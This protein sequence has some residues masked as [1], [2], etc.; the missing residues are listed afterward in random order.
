M[1]PKDYWFTNVIDNP[2]HTG[3]TLPTREWYSHIP[4]LCQEVKELHR[5]ML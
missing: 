2:I 4:P 3:D 5:N 1:S